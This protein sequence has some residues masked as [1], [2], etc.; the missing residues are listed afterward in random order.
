MDQPL[1]PHVSGGDQ[2]TISREEFLPR[3]DQLAEKWRAHRGV[4]LEI[5]H[6]AG[7]LLND[8]FGPPTKRQKRGEQ[9]LKEA[10]ERLRT[11][12][13]ELSRM[14][15]FA[16][17]FES[18]ADLMEKYPD[19]TTWTAVKGLLPKL[20]PQGGRQTG[21]SGNGT[22][23]SGGRKQARP[24]QFGRVKQALANLSSKLRKAREV[25]SEDEKKELRQQFQ[26]L[27]KAI[28]DC[29]QIPVSV[30]QVSAETAPPAAPAE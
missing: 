17:S 27:A 4:D 15:R 25:L 30:G 7:K 20:K 6:E 5:R 23:S 3:L 22:A 19:A 13:S 8:H 1:T 14:R 24:V 11:T 29:L 2:G 21:G 12:E 16:S 10:A 26:E 18:F 9:V 28:S